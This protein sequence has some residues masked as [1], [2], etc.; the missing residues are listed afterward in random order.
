MRS[1]AVHWIFTVSALLKRSLVSCAFQAKS[2]TPCVPE[3]LS[4]RRPSPRRT[5][6]VQYHPP[7]IV[8]RCRTSRSAMGAPSIGVGGGSTF[9]AADSPAALSS[10]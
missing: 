6:P 1:S 8:S 9:G 2:D 10:S 5:A 7:G 3:V 4:S